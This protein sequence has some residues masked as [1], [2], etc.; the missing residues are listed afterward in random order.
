MKIATRNLPELTL[1]VPNFIVFF[2]FLSMFLYHFPLYSYAFSN[3]GFSLSGVLTFSI[4]L[5]A[6]FIAISFMLFLFALI[7]PFFLK[8]FC[9]LSLLGNSM[10]LYFMATYHVILDKTMMGN[11][12]NTNFSEVI[13]YYH[14]K[15]FLYIVF[16]GIVPSLFVI[17][18]QIK[19]VRR[20]RL[21]FQATIVFIGCVFLSYL[22]AS[23]WLWFDEHAKQ[24][25]G[26]IMPAAYFGNSI[27]Y[28][29]TQLEGSKEQILLPS[30]TFRDNDKMIAVLVIGESARAENFSLLGYP[31]I[32]NPELEKLDVTAIQAT[33]ASTYTTASVNSMLS[34]TG[35]TSDSYEPLPS[36]LQR[37]GVDVIWRTANW[38][39]PKLNVQTYERDGDL[40]A[41]CEGEECAFDE[42]LLTNLSERISSSKKEKIFIV[43]HTSGSHGPLY[44]DKSPNNF[45]YFKPICETVDLG[46]CTSQEVIN[47]YDNTIL[48]TDYFLSKVIK[49]L[50]KQSTISSLMDYISDHCESLGEYGLYLHGTPFMIAPDVQKK[51]PFIFWAS[52]GY[53]RARGVKSFKLKQQ[54]YSHKNIFHTILGAFNMDSS[55]YNQ[56]LDVVFSSKSEK[57]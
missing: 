44:N 40:R 21:I 49:L 25:G 20:L 6:L 28:E 47:A 16:L 52:N 5:V 4:M 51:V 39:E 36:Y 56:K 55:V 37:H 35:A 2:T 22:N 43:L 12:F 26:M 10:A 3:L 34:Y 11:V 1:S 48:Y 8:L 45:R 23:T 29:M 33:A 18:T 9:V 50:N 24:L 53:L 27:R 15:L 46:T 57:W 38:G 32:T 41:S 30:A 19:N 7:S 14:P 31:R 42:V 13:S 17:K 54:D